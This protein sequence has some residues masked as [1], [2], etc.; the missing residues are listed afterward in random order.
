ME[1]VESAKKLLRSVFLPVDRSL[2]RDL[3]PDMLKRIETPALRL[4]WFDW[5]L[6]A[7]VGCWAL[8]LPG[9]ILQLL[10]QF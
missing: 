6:I 4:A 7:L 5:A 9:G 10:Y 8:I 3:W 1:Q 2:P